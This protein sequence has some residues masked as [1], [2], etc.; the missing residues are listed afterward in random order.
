MA[1]TPAE[2][3]KAASVAMNAVPRTGK[4]A[5]LEAHYGTDN[6]RRLRCL[7]AGARQRC[8]NPNNLSY[9]NYGGRGIR[10]GFTGVYD[11]VLYCLTELGPISTDRSVDRIDNEAGYEPGNIRWATPDEQARN[12]R[13][14]KRTHVGRAIRRVLQ[15]RDDLT[16]ETVRMWLRSGVTEQEAMTRGKY[17]RTSL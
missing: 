15:H 16:Y 8:E 10:F 4:Y 17:A 6:V 5:A 3:R 11:A 14:Y 13:Q 9:A 2:V 7:L 1:K 12:K